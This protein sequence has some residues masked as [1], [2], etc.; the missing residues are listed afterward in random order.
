MTL[1]KVMTYC[2]SKVVTIF[3][4]FFLKLS[5]VSPRSLPSD[6]TLTD[7]LDSYFNEISLA[8]GSLVEF[9]CYDTI[10]LYLH[11]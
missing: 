5:N 11:L 4:T 7:N 2:C 6:I 8:D 1:L 3:I 10:I 9:L